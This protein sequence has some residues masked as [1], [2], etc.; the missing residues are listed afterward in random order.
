[1][2]AVSVPGEPEAAHLVRVIA[3]DPVKMAWLREHGGRLLTAAAADLRAHPTADPV[4]RLE[5]YAAAYRA[6]RTPLW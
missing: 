4:T 1:M 5:E 2:G 6:G 3:A